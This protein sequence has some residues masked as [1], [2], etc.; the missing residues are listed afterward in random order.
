MRTFF[1]GLLS[2]AGNHWLLWVVAL[3]ALDASVGSWL[4][5]GYMQA[6]GRMLV[7]IETHMRQ[8]F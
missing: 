1:A 2:V 8:R 7:D 6:L 3:I 5:G 4:Y